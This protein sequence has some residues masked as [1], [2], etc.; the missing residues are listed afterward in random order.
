MMGGRGCFCDEVA[1][2]ATSMTEAGGTSPA[3]RFSIQ[4]GWSL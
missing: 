1:A 4:G 2:E 3:S